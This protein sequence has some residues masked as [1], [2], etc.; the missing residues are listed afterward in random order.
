M[1]SLKTRD[2][3]AIAPVWPR[4]PE[5]FGNGPQSPN[6]GQDRPD[7]PMS[8]SNPDRHAAIPHLGRVT[9]TPQ[10]E[11]ASQ[12]AL[13]KHTH[14]HTCLFASLLGPPPERDPFSEE[15]RSSPHVG[16]RKRTRSLRRPSFSQ[17]RWG[18]VQATCS[19]GV[20]NT[21]SCRTPSFER[22]V[23]G[24]RPSETSGRPRT[25]PIIGNR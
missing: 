1:I 6:L 11:S 10:H 18:S 3:A 4:S 23:P 16:N 17:P 15:G 24:A 9:P 19:E 8:G 7:R 21:E 5:S 13:R 25:M 22:P 2:W 20:R 14:T 12:R